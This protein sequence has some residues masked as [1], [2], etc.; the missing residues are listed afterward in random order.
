M[1]N[2]PSN[3]ESAY[4]TPLRGLNEFVY[5]PR[6]FH[7][8]YVQGI[9]SDSVE[10]LSGTI[11]HQKRLTK[12]KAA[13]ELKKSSEESKTPTP[14]RM[15]VVREMILSSESLGITGKFDVILE[16]NDEIIP[17]EVKRGSAPDGKSPFIVGQFELSSD[18]WGNDQLQLA[19]QIVLLR[20]AGHNCCKGKLYYQKT[21]TLVEIELSNSLQSALQWVVE[22]TSTLSKSD[23]PDPLVDSMKCIRCSLNHV[24]LPDETLRIKGK[25][26][27]PRQLFPGRDDIGVLYLT[28]PG[29]R[30]GKS[31][32]TVKITVPD[33]KPHTI[34]M[35]EI[36]HVCCSGNVQVTTQA[37]LSL[38]DRSVGISWLT[39]GGWLKAT[40]F[41]PLEKNVHLRR[42]QYRKCEDEQVCL[43]L[44]KWIVSSKIANQR[45]LV[46]RNRKE[47]AFDTELQ[48][49]DECKENAL[50]ATTLDSLRG[51]E[52]YAAKT[53]WALF[54]KLLSNEN[55]L[56]L[57]MKG[58]NKR[59]PKDP[60]NALLSYGYTMLV[61]DFV[62]A[63][64]SAGMD[65][66]FGFYHSVVPGRPAL[67]L[68]LMEA[69]R[70]LV[71]DSAVLRG[72][73]ENSFTS[74][75]FTVLKSYCTM[76]PTTKKRWIQAYE[77]RV[78]QLITHPLFGYRLSYRR[79]FHLE[80]RLL[81]RFFVGELNEYQP[82]TTR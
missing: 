73:N 22:Q 8:M 32:E 40:T 15:D 81:G 18:A 34:P 11:S 54:P 80:T 1:N 50:V 71:V 76:K 48:T 6:L 41:A 12:T 42:E 35:K 39:G 66:L 31:G 68:D 78:D 2:S 62:T 60:V 61:R 51:I 38:T 53:Y 10:T 29:T 77:R 33:E 79:L 5:C 21:K 26:E 63:I 47:D 59:P 16:N 45:V 13:K 24:C 72:I 19:G 7:L 3:K 58:R 44:A 37:M 75:D 82:I 52:G 17:V 4:L 43:K 36:S 27:E 67:A 70:H 74:S 57:T 65:P 56:R 9:F 69:F 49:L 64:H 46:R 23:M 30:L 28:T 14:W 20:D 55:A 25:V